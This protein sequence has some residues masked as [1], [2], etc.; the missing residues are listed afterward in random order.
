MKNKHTLKN[1]VQ[2]CVHD[3]GM[4]YKNAY[5]IADKNLKENIKLFKQ[6]TEVK[7]QLLKQLLKKRGDK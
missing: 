4:T 7:K 2:K 1:Y 5:L 6:I 3:Y